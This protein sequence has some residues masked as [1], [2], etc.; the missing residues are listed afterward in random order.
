MGSAQVYINSCEFVYDSL[1]E[2]VA[3]KLVRGEKY[4]LILFG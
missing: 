1:I 2:N 4:E 3:H